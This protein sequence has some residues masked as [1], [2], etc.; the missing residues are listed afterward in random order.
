LKMKQFSTISKKMPCISAWN[1]IISAGRSSNTDRR[2]G[3]VVLF[4]SLA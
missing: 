3:K 4:R 1:R 2:S